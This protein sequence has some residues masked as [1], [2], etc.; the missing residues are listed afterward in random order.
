[1]SFS[2]LRLSLC[3]RQGFIQKFLFGV[4]VGVALS[5]TV[6]PHEVLHNVF[7][8]TISQ[9]YKF[10]YLI[11]AREMLLM[12]NIIVPK[13][14]LLPHLSPIS[15]S[16]SLLFSFL[17]FF[18]WRGG[19]SWAFWGG[20]GGSFPPAPPLDETLPSKILRYEYKLAIEYNVHTRINVYAC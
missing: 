15:L 5:R 19:G 1:M 20:G 11:L 16:L 14:I 2:Q 6:G 13:Y 12:Y 3:P 7:L 8:Y 9:Y 4:E 18:F 17:L 10:N